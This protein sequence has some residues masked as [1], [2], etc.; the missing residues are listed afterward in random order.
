MAGLIPGLLTAG[1]Y[2]VM[3][4]GRVMIQP[5]L[6]PK[7]ALKVPMSEKLSA[8]ASVWPMPLLVLGVVGSIYGGIAT[9]TEAGALGATFAFLIGASQGRLTKRA[10][11]DAVGDALSTTSSLFFLAIGAVMLTRFLAM[12]GVPDYI[13]DVV[14]H[15]DLGPV[16]LVIA[17]SIIY[18]ILGMFLDPI[19]V[20][21]LTLPVF[22]PAFHAL[23]MD[24]IWIGVIVVKMIEIGLL[25]P[26]VG[27]NVYV[28]KGVAGDSVP[29]ATVFRGVAWFLACEL[30]IMILL[31]AFPALST[32]L[33]S[34]ASH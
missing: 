16:Q 2:T 11:R 6:A 13:A 28:V 30:V 7:V 32:W 17:M 5:K 27:L 33:P 9:P 31:V 24:L 12:A 34:L 23:D 4:V 29:L 1:L 19:G 20:M 8:L 14:T 22:L 25:T 3:I 26:P 15:M 18:L 10:L 21:L